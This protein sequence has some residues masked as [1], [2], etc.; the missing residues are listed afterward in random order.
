MKKDQPTRMGK[1]QSLKP[2]SHLY[3]L[4]RTFFRIAWSFDD[5]STGIGR[6]WVLYLTIWPFL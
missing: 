4:F 6:S 1:Q 3:A 5:N 2:W